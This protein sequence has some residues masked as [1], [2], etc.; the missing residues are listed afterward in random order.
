MRHETSSPL[1]LILKSLPLILVSTFLAFPLLYAFL[2]SFKTLGE[3]TYPPTFFPRS[4]L[5]VDNYLEVF[6]KTPIVRYFL[7]STIIAV[8]GS[9]IEITISVLA[10]YAFAYLDFRGKKFFFF[11]IMGTLMLP[12]E[13]LF[14]GNYLTVAKLGLLDTY[15]GIILPLLASATQILL[16]RQA[17]LSLPGDLYEAALMD[18]SGGLRYIFSIL[19]P[20]TKSFLVILS[21]RAFLSFWNQYLWPLLVTNS[22]KMRTVQIGITMMHN[23]EVSNFGLI[24]AAITIVLLPSLLV[25]I[26]AHD[27]IQEGLISTDTVGSMH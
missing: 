20:T 26:F 3:F 16:L 6:R 21:I 25:F 2:G 14:V 4:F 27:L 11:L 5:N 7:N 10:A 12:G 17:F 15:A 19:I 23:T 22:N 9:F 18:G 24:L 13:T 1:R 8:V